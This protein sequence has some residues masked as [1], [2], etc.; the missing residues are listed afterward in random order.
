M[1]LAALLA[2][3]IGFIVMVVMC[4]RSQAMLSPSPAAAYLMPILLCAGLWFIFPVLTPS[5][6]AYQRDV[7]GRHG[8]TATLGD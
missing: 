1:V 2:V 8:F 3:C 7:T 4:G 6:A 5:A